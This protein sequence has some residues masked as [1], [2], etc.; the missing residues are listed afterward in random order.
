M[1][2]K[3]IAAP[4]LS[5]LLVTLFSC[6]SLKMN[7]RNLV[8]KSYQK[9]CPFGNAK[10][11][12]YWRLFPGIE[13]LDLSKVIGSDTLPAKYAAYQIDF[14]HLQEFLKTF[15]SLPEEKRVI[16]VPVNGG[17]NCL[18]FQ[19]EPSGTLSPTIQKNYPNIRAWKGL[20]KQ[21]AQAQLRLEMDEAKI[22]AEIRQGDK[23]EYISKWSGGQDNNNGSIYYLLYDKKDAR[24]L[25]IPFKSY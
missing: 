18:S 11:R 12:I 13:A 7:K 14:P 20:S 22:S 16:S 24:G 25:N 9:V 8:Q 15:E 19:L 10:A 3:F 21:N 1:K 4:L 2:M 5:A 6:Q 23:I 17:A